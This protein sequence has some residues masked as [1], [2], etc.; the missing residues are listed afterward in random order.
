MPLS[1][2]LNGCNFRRLEGKV[3]LMRLPAVVA[4]TFLDRDQTR[5]RLHGQ[6]EYCRAVRQF[7][8]NLVQVYSSRSY[9][10]T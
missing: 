5:T 6:S 7:V 8:A 2:M 1:L 4:A 10:C 3:W 9:M